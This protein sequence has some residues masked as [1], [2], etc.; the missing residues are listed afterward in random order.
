MPP[1]ACRWPAAALAMSLPDWV[2]HGAGYAQ[3]M[4]YLSQALAQEL[5][6]QGPPVFDTA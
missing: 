4:A 1:P 6:R 2:E 5:A 3:A